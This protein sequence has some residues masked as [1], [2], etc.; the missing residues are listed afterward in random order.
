MFFI[1]FAS[2]REEHRSKVEALHDHLG[3][4]LHLGDETLEVFGLGVGLEVF[5]RFLGLDDEI[6]VIVGGGFIEVVADATFVTE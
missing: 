2:L 4:S 5:F 1:N 3:V 6:T